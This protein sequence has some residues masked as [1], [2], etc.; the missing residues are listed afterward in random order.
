MNTTPPTPIDAAIKHAIEMKDDGDDYVE[1]YWPAV[2]I[3]LAELTAAKARIGEAEKREQLAMNNWNAEA[4]M[5][6]SKLQAAEADSARLR[7]ALTP[8]AETKAAYMGEFGFQ[9]GEY[10]PNVPWTTIKQIMA[11]ILARAALNQG[12]DE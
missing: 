12:A 4:E 5:L 1:S 10:T 7:E 6:G 9:F 3:I 11:A 2:E 8:S